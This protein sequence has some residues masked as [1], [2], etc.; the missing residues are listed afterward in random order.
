[1]ALKGPLL[2]PEKWDH[3]I[4]GEIERLTVEASGM[5]GPLAIRGAKFQAN[6]DKILL[7]DSQVDLLDTSLKISPT[8]NGWQQGLRNFEGTFQGNLGA[9]MVEWAS[10]RTHLPE[11]RRIRA[12]LFISQTRIGW[13]RENGISFTGNCEWPKGPA[14]YIDL[15]YPP[16]VL[17]VKRMLITDDHSQ[18]EIGLKVQHK[19]LL[20]DFKGNL[21]KVTVDRVLLKNEFHADSIRGGIFMPKSLSMTFCAQ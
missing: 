16:N 10:A 6:P 4:T 9:K 15:R 14:V 12:P 13:D 7:R 11:D 21:E 18:A 1:M 2:Q 19:E 17:A 20:L 5:P 3:Q 8:G